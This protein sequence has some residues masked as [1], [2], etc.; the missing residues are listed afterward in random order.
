MP[1]FSRKGGN[2]RSWLR[3]GRSEVEEAVV[4]VELESMEDAWRRFRRRHRERMLGGVPLGLSSSEMGCRGAH[5]DDGELLEP[6]KE[7][8]VG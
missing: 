3:A 1:P 2:E 7:G 5:G 8:E 6:L 4:C